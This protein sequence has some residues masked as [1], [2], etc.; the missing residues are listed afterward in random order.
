MDQSAD[1]TPERRREPAIRTIMLPKD[2]NQNGTIFGG[3]ILSHIDLAGTVDA[4]RQS[5]NIE[6][7]ATVAMDKIEFI[8]PVF[9]GDIVSFYT[10]IVRVGRTSIKVQV[11]VEVE[12]V[13]PVEEKVCPVT[14][15]EVTYVSLDPKT[16]RPRPLFPEKEDG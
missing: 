14:T 12:R 16:Q 2:T 4:R 10:K 5:P 11:E 15:A 1:Q 6:M 9:V 3:I 8:A 13:K 7:L